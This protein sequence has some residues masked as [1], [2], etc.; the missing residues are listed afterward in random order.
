M[1]IKV[2]RLKF[3]K[4]YLPLLCVFCTLISFSARGMQDAQTN[5]FNIDN[6]IRILFLPLAALSILYFCVKYQLINFHCIPSPIKWLFLYSLFGIFSMLNGSWFAYSIVKLAEY[7]M[8]LF[9]GYYICNVDLYKEKFA[10]KAYFYMISFLRFLIVTVL[11]GL[12][13]SPAKALHFGEN[14]YS[15]IREAFLPFILRGWIVPL[16]STS[17]AMISAI[18]SFCEIVRIC[19]CRKNVWAYLRLLLFLLCMLFAQSRTAFL[20]FSLVVIIYFAFYYKNSYRKFFWFGVILIALIFIVPVINDILLRGQSIKQFQTFSGRT[21]WWN[22]AW[23]FFCNSSFINQLF[24]NGFA[25][26]ERIVAFNSNNVMNTLD[27]EYFALLISN[28]IIGLVCYVGFSITT[29]TLLLRLLR[30]IKNADITDKHL[31][32]IIHQVVGIFIIV[33]V[34]TFTVTTLAV[35]TYYLVIVVFSLCVLNSIMCSSKKLNK[36]TQKN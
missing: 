12:I 18:L 23:N 7:L 4:L 35:H 8:T 5:L 28:G 13:L 10:K 20:G 3:D 31:I 2:L 29:I 16:T 6:W 24:G 32:S 34:R 33:F 17:V 21:V 36:G 26:G 19:E 30:K 11:I 9:C 27:S 1:K 22:Y 14:E 25:A 15:A